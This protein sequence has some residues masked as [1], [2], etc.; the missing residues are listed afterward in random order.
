MSSITIDFKQAAELL[1]MF[2]GE[3]GL[4]TLQVARLE[5]DGH[6]GAGLYAYYEDMPEE[7][8]IHLGIPDEDSEPED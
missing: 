5:K 4:I 6:S 1:D 8:A 2:G 7:G 3:P